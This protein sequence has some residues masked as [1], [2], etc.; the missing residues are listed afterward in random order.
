MDLEEVE[1][2]PLNHVRSETTFT[3]SN[4][5]RAR[6]SRALSVAE[7]TCGSGKHLSRC[8]ANRSGKPIGVD[9][10]ASRG[11]GPIWKGIR[12]ERYAGERASLARDGRLRARL[13][14]RHS[15]GTPR[16]SET[17]AGHAWVASL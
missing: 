16:Q 6:K 15:G 9:H 1:E 14:H 8:P 11:D 10:V 12:R 13:L 2:E 7:R 5:G 17:R 4:S 3:R